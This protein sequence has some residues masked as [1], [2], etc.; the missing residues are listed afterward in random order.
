MRFGILGPVRA[1]DVPLGGARLRALL[2]MLLLDA[3]RVVPVDRL[4]DGLYGERPPAGAVNAV[5]SQVSRLRSALPVEFDGAGYR[6]A[7]DPDEVDAHRFARL[8]AAG[9]DAL[10]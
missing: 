9:H 6:L 7:I 4:I 10:V 1:A 2:A 3:G 8:A 5:Q